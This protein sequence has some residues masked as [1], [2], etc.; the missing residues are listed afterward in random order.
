MT[1]PTVSFER[2]FHASDKGRDNFLS[3]VFGIFSEEIVRA[4]CRAED[5]PYCDLGRPSLYE[6]G[7]RVATLDFTLQSK[8]T[9]EIFVAEQKC[10]LAFENYKYLQLKSA[11]DLA[12]H[13][14]K[15]FQRFLELAK[16]PD[17][18]GLEAQDRI[19]GQEADQ[20]GGG[21]KP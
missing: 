4:W 1:T 5:C 21:G 18:P 12:H 11:Q 6:N 8:R 17:Q 7:R 2:L 15:A 13:T 3:R 19:P 10:E 14:S 20:K 9:G 16:K